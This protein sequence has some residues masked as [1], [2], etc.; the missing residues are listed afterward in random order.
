MVYCYHDHS[1]KSNMLLSNQKLG[2]AVASSG[3]P[4]DDLY[5]QESLEEI[6]MRLDKLKTLTAPLFSLMKT[7]YTYEEGEDWY[8]DFS[9]KEVPF[10]ATKLANL[11]VLVAYLGNQR[12]RMY[13]ECLLLGKTRFY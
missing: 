2:P 11:K 9:I 5:L 7:E 3:P 8:S 6:S 13:G 1:S 12:Q 4:G 10:S